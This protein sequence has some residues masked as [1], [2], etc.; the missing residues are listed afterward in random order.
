MREATQCADKF[1][2]A[3]GVCIDWVKLEDVSEHKR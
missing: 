2:G 3:W 1:E